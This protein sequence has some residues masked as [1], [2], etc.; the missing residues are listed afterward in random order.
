MIDKIWNDLD[1][2]FVNDF[3]H[4]FN[5]DFNRFFKDLIYDLKFDL[6]HLKKIIWF[7][8]RFRFWWFFQNYLIYI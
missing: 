1:L 6:N 4:D 5:H 8:L 3:N 2:D 7:D